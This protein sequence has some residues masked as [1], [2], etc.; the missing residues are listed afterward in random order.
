MWWMSDE[1]PQPIRPRHEWSEVQD[2][3][4]R[5]DEPSPDRANRHD[6]R[7]RPEDDRIGGDDPAG[8]PAKVKPTSRQGHQQSD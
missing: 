7:Q 6:H 2:E 8:Q 4:K 3:Q 5:Q 1:S